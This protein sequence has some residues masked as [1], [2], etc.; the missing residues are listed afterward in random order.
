MVA[1]E[2]TLAVLLEQAAGLLSTQSSSQVEAFSQKLLESHILT[3]TCIVKQ[4]S[5]DIQVYESV[6]DAFKDM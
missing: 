1:H 6:D 2:A 5:L 3:I 4:L